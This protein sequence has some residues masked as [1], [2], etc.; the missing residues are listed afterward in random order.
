M[1]LA[2][3]HEHAVSGDCRTEWYGLLPGE[4]SDRSRSSFDE[5]VRCEHA[6]LCYTGTL[7]LLLSDKLSKVCFP[8]TKVAM[9]SMG[10]LSDH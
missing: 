6:F 7:M 10:S 3:L 4:R 1:E 2:D 9:F 8:D 5:T